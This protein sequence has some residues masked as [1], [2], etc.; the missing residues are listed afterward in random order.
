MAVY[1]DNAA[2][3]KPCEEAVRAVVRC[4]KENYGNPSSLHRMGIDAEAAMNNARR[5]IASALS[6]DPACLYF[7]SGATES[8]N[9]AIFGAAS[10]YGRRKRKIIT[11]AV[12]H[13][14]VAE[15]MKA[16]EEQGFEVIRVLPRNGLFKTED[17]LNAADDNTAFISMMLVN[18]ET[19]V[20]LPVQRVF[21]AL[22]R[23]FPDIITHCDCVQGF[24]KLPLR[25]TALGADMATFSAHK[26]Y[27]PKGAG[28]LYIAKNARL[29]P[30][31]FGGHQE[32]GL[33]SGTEPVPAIAGFGA[34]AKAGQETLLAHLAL[35]AENKAF[36]L[37]GLARLTD[38]GINSPPDEDASPYIVN[39]SVRGIRSEILL[40]YLEEREIFVSSGSACAKGAQS[41]VLKMFGISDSDADC[42][43]R[44]SMSRDTNAQELKFLLNALSDGI[45]KLRR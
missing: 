5:S 42:A 30:R 1:L 19:G 27:G 26:I 15:P 12:E 21:T 31:I 43:L 6:C 24:M 22:K 38:I 41:S 29:V 13:P 14:S 4:M 32:K 16:L 2:T 23:R 37:R 11:T 20:I 9:L 8:N 34:A 36:L 40:H 28:A 10:A 45:K 3:T 25:L 39:F 35:A 17:F 33:R 18:N 7:T 44:V